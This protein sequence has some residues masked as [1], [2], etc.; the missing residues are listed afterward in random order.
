MNFKDSF[1]LLS[2]LISLSSCAQ[3][4][5]E[6]ENDKKQETSAQKKSIAQTL[7][8]NSDLSIEER[9]SLYE[10]LKWESPEE[11]NFENEDE[12]TMYGYRHLWAGELEDALEIFELSKNPWAKPW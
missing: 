11:Y 1:I 4:N 5:S 7:E 9:I 8:E 12:M 2:L 3:T 10:K 6:T